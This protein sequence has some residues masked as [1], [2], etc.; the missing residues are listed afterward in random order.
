MYGSALTAPTQEGDAPP[1][2]ALCIDLIRKENCCV[3]FDGLSAHE[4]K[5]ILHAYAI[6]AA[7]SWM[8]HYGALWLSPANRL[9]VSQLRQIKSSRPD[10]P[11]QH[12]GAIKRQQQLRST[13]ES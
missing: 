13:A 12:F 11:K 6:E 7:P 9:L 5:M 3:A 1:L 2:M 4:R 10:L 8:S